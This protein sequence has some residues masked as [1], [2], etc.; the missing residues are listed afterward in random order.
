V[1]AWLKG[2]LFLSGLTE[3]AGL[4]LKEYG[5][6]WQMKLVEGGH[7]CYTIEGIGGPEGFRVWWAILGPAVTHLLMVIGAIVAFKS[8]WRTLGPHRILSC[9][10][11]ENREPLSFRDKQIS[12]ESIFSASSSRHAT[13]KN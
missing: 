6:I 13:Q 8:N 1:P 2:V 12:M 9:L 7:Y 11:C 4:Y 10:A 3:A 5:N